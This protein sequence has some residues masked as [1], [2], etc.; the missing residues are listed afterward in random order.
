MRQIAVN[1]PDRVAEQAQKALEEGWFNNMDDLVRTA[2]AD[3]FERNAHVAMEQQQ[4][5][6]IEWA[7]QKRA[8]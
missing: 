6:D 3:F 1:L 8:S 2:L 4:L 7:K 5:A